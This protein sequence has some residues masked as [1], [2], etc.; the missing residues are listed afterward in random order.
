M[1]KKQQAI[2]EYPK[3]VE[4]FMD[5][6]NY[7]L[8]SIRKQE[9]SAFNGQVSFR[10]YRVTVEV[11]DEPNEVLAERLEKLWLE[12]DNMHHWEPL[13]KA[14]ESIGYTFKGERGSQRKKQ[15]P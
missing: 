6:G 11:I 9:P 12:C 2:P 3:T 7:W 10:K 4:T 13:R 8:A 1:K 5:V 15:K 14:A